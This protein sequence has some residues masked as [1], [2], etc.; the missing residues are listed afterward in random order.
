MFLGL[1]SSRTHTGYAVKWKSADAQWN[2]Y[3]DYINIM[4]WRDQN[5]NIYSKKD[6]HE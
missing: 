5:Q 2:V 3:K 6:Q 4:K 1:Y